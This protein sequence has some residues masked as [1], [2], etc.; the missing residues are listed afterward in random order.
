MAQTS[1]MR[2]G[3]PS[4]VT[5]TARRVEQA[6]GK[7]ATRAQRRMDETLPWYAA[8][9]AQ[10]RATVGAIVQ[11]GIRG[12]A[13]W[14]TDPDS[15]PR[16]TADVFAVGPQELARVISL[17]QTVDL[18]RIAVETVEEAV[19]ELAGP[20]QQGPLRESALRYS[21]EIAFAAAAVYA[22]AAEQRGAWDARLEA[23]VVDAVIRG[24]LSDS[25]LSRASALGWAHPSHVLVAAGGA[26]EGDTE[27]LLSH[28]R[29]LARAAGADV[30]AGVQTARLVVVIGTD[31]RPG[32]AIRAVLP[33]FADGH[34]V[35]GPVVGDIVQA[36]N[37]VPDVLSALRAAPGWP[38]APRPVTSDA[39]L[40]ERVLA[41]DA[42]AGRA[43]LAGIF[44]PLAADRVLLDTTDAYLLAGG[45]IEATARALFVHPN[46][47][48]Y[49]LRRIADVCGHDLADGRDRYVVQ[50]A[51][52]LGRLDGVQRPL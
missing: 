24:D 5:A 14:L 45:A 30:L 52:A 22:R 35:T 10:P 41:G 11:A 51:L 13:N 39:L 37:S 48:R 2:S 18:I 46:T 23:L 6:S 25:L 9:P 44:E 4:R 19:T 8:L 38:G 12:F 47:V 29:H 21:R 42:R 20:A 32:R 50:V 49:R 36:A 17:E 7:L 33:A 28:V 40:A 26:P 16:I 43:L 27:R 15:G 3:T 34:V 31:A 1:R